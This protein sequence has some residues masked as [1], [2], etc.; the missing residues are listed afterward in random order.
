MYLHWRILLYNVVKI[1]IDLK[2]NFM[3]IAMAYNIMATC[4]NAQSYLKIFC[5]PYFYSSIDSGEN[6]YIFWYFKSMEK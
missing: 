1:D 3:T 2:I 5:Y 4:V 6:V